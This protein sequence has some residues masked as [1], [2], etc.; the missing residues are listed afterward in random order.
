MV[1]FSLDVLAGRSRALST[2]LHCDISDVV[3]VA[4]PRNHIDG[5]C[6]SAL[7]R[8]DACSLASSVR[9]HRPRRMTR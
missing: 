7:G 1:G 8:Y 2:E 5:D 3:T 9:S 6:A 4:G